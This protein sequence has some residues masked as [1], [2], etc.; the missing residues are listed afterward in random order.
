MKALFFFF[1]L[2]QMENQVIVYDWLL[3]LVG[4]ILGDQIFVIGSFIVSCESFFF[5]NLN[6]KDENNPADLGLN[7]VKGKP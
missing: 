5:F 3:A 6:D 4:Y 1:N 7:H 2:K